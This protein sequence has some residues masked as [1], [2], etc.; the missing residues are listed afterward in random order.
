M[1]S[2]D[3]KLL[4]IEQELSI[5]KMILDVTPDQL[6]LPYALWTRKAVRDLVKREFDIIIS[7]TTMGYYLRSWGFSPQKPIKKAFEQNP[8]AEK[9][10]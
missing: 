6:K 3:R 5:Q 10:G 7:L 1:K 8:K 4:K 2:E 9:N